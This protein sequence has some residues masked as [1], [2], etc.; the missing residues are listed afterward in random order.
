MG[1]IR[2]Q[3]LPGSKECKRPAGVPLREH[4]ENYIKRGK[5]KTAANIGRLVRLSPWWF[6]AFS[7][8]RKVGVNLI[9]TGSST[10]ACLLGGLSRVR[11]K[12]H[13][14]FLGGLGLVT[15][16]GYPVLAYIEAQMLKYGKIYWFNF[17]IFSFKL[18]GA[19]SLE[20]E[21][22]RNDFTYS[23]ISNS[24]FKYDAFF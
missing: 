10:R 12:S 19:F 14:R 7:R 5:Q 18:K 3:T 9:P 22:F 2:V 23:W 16:P 4:W 21:F 1:W 13:A 8:Y 6:V 11:W 17:L 15:A 20:I 24:S